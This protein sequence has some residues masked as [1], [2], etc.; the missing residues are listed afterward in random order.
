MNEDNTWAYITRTPL[1]TDVE[2]KACD[3]IW[4]GDS[5]ALQSHKALHLLDA[6][7]LMPLTQRTSTLSELCRALRPH[8]RTRCPKRTNHCEI[9]MHLCC[10]IAMTHE[11]QSKRVNNYYWDVNGL[12]SFPFLPT[13]RTNKE[14]QLLIR[15]AFWTTCTL[16]FHSQ[17]KLVTE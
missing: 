2:L 10:K 12:H 3:S 14:L 17:G 1:L 7:A 8:L 13:E 11:S 4:N 15:E 9:Q 5:F 16:V 6:H